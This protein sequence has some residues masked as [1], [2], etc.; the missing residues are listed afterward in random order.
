MNNNFNNN[1]SNQGSNQRNS[2]RSNNMH[3]I[4]QQQMSAMSNDPFFAGNMMQGGF[5]G[6][7]MDPF[8]AMEQQ[9]RQMMSSFGN[10]QA[11][12]ADPFGNPFGSGLPNGM[13]S[14]SVSYS[15]TTYS[16]TGSNGEVQTFSQSSHTMNDGR[17]VKTTSRSSN[18]RAL[19]DSSRPDGRRII[20]KEMKEGKRK[21]ENGVLVYEDERGMRTADDRNINN[22]NSNNRRVEYGQ[23]NRGQGVSNELSVYEPGSQLSRSNNNE[24]IEQT[25]SGVVRKGRHMGIVDGEEREVEYYHYSKNPTQD[26]YQDSVEV[27]EI[28]SDDDEIEIIE[29]S[30][31]NES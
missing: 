5:F 1:G 2:R 23:L 26:R 29:P 15:S 22:Y 13:G 20:H 14:S 21:L 30:N 10:N 3:D 18:E 8:A 27:Q 24:I 11:L 19:L 6:G 7:M 4:M 28:R 25:N 12:M 31:V 17:N 16:S 9:H